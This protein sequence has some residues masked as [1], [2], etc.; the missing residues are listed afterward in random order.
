MSFQI[1]ALPAETF[2]HFFALPDESVAEH[3]ARRMTVSESPGVPCRV[4]LQDA[5]VGEEVMLVNFEH[6][7][8]ASPYQS[9]HAVYV[10]KDARQA[11]PEIGEV[12]DMLRQRLISLRAF[13]ADGMIVQADVVEGIELEDAIEKLLSLPETQYIHLHFAKPGCF[14]ASVTRA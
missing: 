9:R 10:R 8:A 7:Q 6:Q 4:S 14:A 12:P 3:K 5:R 13:D 11:E 1:H 2:T